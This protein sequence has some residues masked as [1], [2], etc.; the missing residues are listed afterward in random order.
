MRPL[1][2]EDD[3]FATTETKPNGEADSPPHP[4]N[5]HM[6]IRFVLVIRFNQIF[7]S[8]I[9]TLHAKG[10]ENIAMPTFYDT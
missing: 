2:G 7:Q 8:L 9:L 5:I 1:G 4:D 6:Y 10:L 3:R